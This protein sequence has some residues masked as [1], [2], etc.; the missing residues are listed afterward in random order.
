M[1]IKGKQKLQ[2]TDKRISLGSPIQLNAVSCADCCIFNDLATFTPQGS[3]HI[4]VFC[5][6]NQ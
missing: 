5:S 6:P 2:G 4:N 3:K 1:Q